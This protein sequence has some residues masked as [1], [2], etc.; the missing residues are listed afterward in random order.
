ML[1]V[2]AEI[3]L[4]L[5]R[6]DRQDADDPTIPALF[7]VREVYKVPEVDFSGEHLSFG[8][9]AAVG[10]GDLYNF[11]VKRFYGAFPLQNRRVFRL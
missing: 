10:A 4:C 9:K 2:R 8:V 7:A 1:L 3:H 6:F 11:F 5:N